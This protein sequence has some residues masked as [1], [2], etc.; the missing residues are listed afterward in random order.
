MLYVLHYSAGSVAV[1]VGRYATGH[2][3]P[4]YVIVEQALS[5][6][7]N[8]L[9][10]GSDKFYDAAFDGFVAYALARNLSLTAAYVDLGSIATVKGQR[11]AF[12]SLQTSF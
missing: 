2:C 3:A 9:A 10:V 4:G 5:L 1:A 8:S 12:L 7:D 11:G 6:F